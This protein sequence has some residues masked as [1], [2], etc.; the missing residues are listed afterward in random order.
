M[1]CCT[2]SQLIMVWWVL[3]VSLSDKGTKPSRWPLAGGRAGGCV[4]RALHGIPC[5]WCVWCARMLDCKPSWLM[6]RN[7]GVAR[8]SQRAS[9]SDTRCC[10]VHTPL[11]ATR[12]VTNT[13]RDCTCLYL[14]PCLPFAA[15]RMDVCACQQSAAS[16]IAPCVRVDSSSRQR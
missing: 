8:D 1:I 4:W 7:V 16:G 15:A 12:C 13:L 11:G 14:V 6:Y 9:G 5:A 10:H 3:L 2:H